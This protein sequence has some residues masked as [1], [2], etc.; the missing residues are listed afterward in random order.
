MIKLSKDILKK[1]TRPIKVL[2]FGEG[3]FLRAFVDW[4]IQELNEKADFNGNVVV[5]QPLPQG[6]IEDLKAQDG[7][8]TLLLEGIDGGEVVQRTKVIDVLDSFVNPYDSFQDYLAL[9]RNSDLEIIFSNTTEAGIIFKKEKIVKDICP[10]NFPAKL[11]LLLKERYDFFKGDMNKGL[12][13]VPCELIDYNG[14]LLNEALNKVALF[15]DMDKEFI[16]WL[17]EANTFCSTLVDRI[18]P[19]YPRDTADKIEQELGYSDS[20][21][22]KGEVFHLW[23]IEDKG[24]IR[25]ILGS[26]KIEELNILFTD[27]ITPYKQRKVRI[28]NG[29]HTS[30]VP[31]SFLYG[32]DTVPDSMADETIGQFVKDL[33]HQE[34]IPA[35]T[36]ILSVEELTLFASEVMDRFN[37]PY[38]RHRLLDISLNSTT[39]Y[40]T[41]ILPTVLDY[42]RMEN[43]LPKRLLFSLAS[44]IVF[45]K[46]ERDGSSFPTKDDE[47]FLV[48]YKELWTAYDNTLN[49]AQIIASHILGLKDHWG[50]DLNDIDGVTTFIAESIYNIDSQGMK[51]ALKKVM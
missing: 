18:V 29:A 12:H 16:N 21:L 15:E 41:R 26:D 42:I 23:V 39:K 37:N 3:N 33:V 28:L 11:I 25:E 14:K 4:S 20:S 47:E 31:V 13:I 10:N 22:V 34:I 32:L 6:R 43:K 2:Q 1:T 51:S 27:D 36:E 17:N 44:L 19:G 38:I 30:M 46:G 35:T 8:Y 50:V 49:G 5:V 45:F 7:L 40:K 24:N 48:M 9:A